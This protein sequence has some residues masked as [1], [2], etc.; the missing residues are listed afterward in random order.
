MARLPKIT[1]SMARNIIAVVKVAGPVLLPF[2][3]K[4]AASAREAYE[5]NRARRLGVP[6]AEIGQYS[7]R[8][9]ALHARLNNVVTALDDLPANHAAFASE[10]GDTARRLTAAVRAAE[11]MPTS[12]RR[13]VHKAVSTEL[14]SI[15]TGLA[16]RLLDR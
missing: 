3:I 9:G 13:S 2:A 15:E 1:P 8:G 11:H 6:L 10:A 12:R 7:G 16:E 4:A 5:K 14:D